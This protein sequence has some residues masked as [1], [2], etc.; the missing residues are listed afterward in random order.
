MSPPHQDL[1]FLEVDDREAAIPHLDAVDRILTDLRGRDRILLDLGPGD[2]V[3]LELSGTHAVA[4][5]G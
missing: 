1:T 3:L 4:G 2:R 5:K